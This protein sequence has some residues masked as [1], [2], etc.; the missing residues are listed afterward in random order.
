MAFLDKI[1]A[2]FKLILGSN[3]IIKCL[4]TAVSSVG[5]YNIMLLAGKFIE[6]SP[7]SC[8]KKLY[9]ASLTEKA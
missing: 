1:K 8:C 2:V 5:R 6:N 3:P 7:N 9:F 4:K